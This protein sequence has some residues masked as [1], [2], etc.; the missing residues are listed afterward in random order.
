MAQDMRPISKARN[1]RFMPSGV[2]RACDNS[3]QVL[4]GILV[5]HFATAAGRTPLELDHLDAMTHVLA[6]ATAEVRFVALLAV[7]HLQVI[8]PDCGM[9]CWEKTQNAGLGVDERRS[10]LQHSSRVSVDAAASMQVLC[11][12]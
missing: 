5:Q 8:E 7:Q 11:H 1:L 4:Y 9:L 2:R 12:A 6:P 3:T 10:S